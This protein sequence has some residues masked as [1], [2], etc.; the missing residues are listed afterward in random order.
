MNK[1]T[2]KFGSVYMYHHLNEP[3]YV[4]P[5]LTKNIGGSCIQMDFA[6][7]SAWYQ[8]E[9]SPGV[10]DWTTMDKA[11]DACEHAGIEPMPSLCHHFAPH[12]WV[13]DGPFND[14]LI[15]T[16]EY[17]SLYGSEYGRLTVAQKSFADF[18]TAFVKRYRKRTNLYIMSHEYNLAYLLT[19]KKGTPEYN[20]LITNQTGSLLL[21]YNIIK[22]L[23]P[24][25]KFTYG[26]AVNYLRDSFGG[27]PITPLH[28][29]AERSPFGP[30]FMINK[31]VETGNKDFL[32]LMKTTDI[33]YF[34]YTT[35]ESADDMVPIYADDRAGDV[36]E[37]F[38][39]G[40]TTVDGKTYYYR[41]YVKEIIINHLSS[42]G[43]WLLN[44]EHPYTESQQA[45]LL[46]GSLNNILTAKSRGVP[47]NRILVPL[48]DK[49]EYVGPVSSNDA[50]NWLYVPEG[51]F[52]MR[53]EVER[54]KKG[55]TVVPKTIT[56]EP[57]KA[58]DAYKKA[59]LSYQESK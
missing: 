38:Y 10:Y 1:D 23:A 57:K 15:D 6:E 7:V 19:T 17:S 18:V 58:V 48:V 40:K 4:G 46:K 49:N 47:I 42:T 45:E 51:L 33:F 24:T 34:G 26:L 30:R 35:L 22:K 21:A 31:Y 53:G 32:D 59:V 50:D 41:D 9:R 39:N 36:A 52:K 28:F 3:E 13:K 55:R 5:V 37:S 2:L 27:E 20:R 12:E 44:P 56:Y 29:G 54:L 8:I 16:P 25:A 11:Y 43:K 14:E